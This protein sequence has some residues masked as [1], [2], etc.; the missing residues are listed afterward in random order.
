MAD[1]GTPPRGWTVSPSTLHNLGGEGDQCSHP[2]SVCTASS[3]HMDNGKHR[4][5]SFSVI[6]YWIMD[7]YNIYAVLTQNSQLDFIEV[8]PIGAALYPMNKAATFE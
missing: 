4:G 8:T 2:Q 5:R 6:Y 1:S 7:V 3:R